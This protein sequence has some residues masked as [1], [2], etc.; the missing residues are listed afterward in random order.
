MI[1]I[2]LFARFEPAVVK[3][4][5]AAGDVVTGVLTERVRDFREKATLRAADKPRKNLDCSTVLDGYPQ[6]LRV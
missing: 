5:F 1:F 6:R 3:F 2:F 4:K